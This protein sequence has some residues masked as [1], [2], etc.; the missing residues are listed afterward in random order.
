LASGASLRCD[1]LVVGAGL[2]GGS[3]VCA[4]RDSGLKVVVIDSKEPSAATQGWDERVY[5]LSPS[6]QQ[7]LEEIGVWE[8]LAHDRIEAVNAMRIFGDDG[9]SQLAFSSYECAVDRLAT[10]VEAG[11]VH[12]ALWNS[13]QSS[14]EVTLLCPASPR[15]ISWGRHS[16]EVQLD[17]GQ[18]IDARLLVAAD[19]MFSKVREAAGI[20]AKIEPAGQKGVVANF[21]CS[22][23]HR[24]VACQWFRKDGVLA[25]LPL[26]GHCF[27]MVWSA[28]DQWA[29]E[30]LRSDERALSQRVF[31]AGGGLWGDLKL[32]SGPTAFPLAWLSVRQR[33][34]ERLALIGDA[35][36][37]VHP[38]A[39]QGINLGL[40]DARELAFQLRK[41][42][43]LGA[44][45][46]E[47]LH[48]RRFERHRAEAILAM[49]IATKGLKRLFEEKS[50]LAGKLRNRGLNLT[51]R[52]L[53]L[54]NMMA[55]HAMG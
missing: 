27:S 49:R 39:G 45:V 35:G 7:F 31:D 51:D 11:A 37:V 16:C 5:A 14:A 17:Q 44:D 36:H 13:L 6:S 4:L 3:L 21:E 9:V 52:T 15:E 50:F 29:D 54:K 55:Q 19:G 42:S 10:I 33:V 23:P 41:A 48:L 18:S 24:G 40:G 8:N 2:A 30:L 25:W 26:P 28:D 46:G 43:K 34:R 1:V 20:R 38:L 22:L 32:L 12:R 47:L 53:V